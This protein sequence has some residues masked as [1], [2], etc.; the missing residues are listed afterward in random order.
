MRR[1]VEARAAPGDT[2]PTC[3]GAPGPG[4][5]GRRAA[6]SV[7]AVGMKIALL[8][9]IVRAAP[10]SFL[11]SRASLEGLMRRFIASAALASLVLLPATGAS[12][13]APHGGGG[14]VMGTSGLLGLAR[15]VGE[16]GSSAGGGAIL[17]YSPSQGKMSVV[18]EVTGLPPYSVHPAHIHA[19]PS[20]TSNGPVLY[21]LPKLVAN[22]VGVAFAATTIDRQSVPASG[23]YVNVH[24]GPD[25]VGSHFTPI[26]CGRVQ[27]ASGAA[28]IASD[29]GVSPSIQG[30]GLIGVGA[31]T[32]NVVVIVSGLTPQTTHPAHIHLGVCGSNGPILYALPPLTPGPTGI[33]VTTATIL[34]TIVPAPGVNGWYINVHQGPTLTGAG[35]TP[36]ACGGVQRPM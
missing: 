9:D 30:V 27:R 13:A 10:F 19:G 16:N 5:I 14:G 8:H 12:A 24:Q 20:C 3:G 18:L 32:S 23:L 36:I 2:C 15:L 21:P 33:A 22:A 34:T 26:A 25:L 29:T 11:P 28:Q 4:K 1:R 17:S 7:S 6:C 35:A 31:T